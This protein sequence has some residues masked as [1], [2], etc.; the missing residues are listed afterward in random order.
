[1]VG[2]N[3]DGDDIRGRFVWEYTNGCGKDEFTI[4]G[5]EDYGWIS[6]DQVDG[7]M[8]EFCPALNDET[9]APTDS[10]TS[11]PTSPFVS[12]APTTMNPTNS[13]SSSPVSFTVYLKYRSF[14]IWK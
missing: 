1:M 7:A 5:G 2:S 8:P 9:N 3:D 13:P 14:H 12:V 11:P 10:P 4:I 6:F